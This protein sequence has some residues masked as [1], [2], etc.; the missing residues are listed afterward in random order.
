MEEGQVDVGPTLV[1]DVEAAEVGEPRHGALGDPAI[2]PQ[3]RAAF[4][5]LPGD[6]VR[7]PVLLQ[8]GVAARDIVGFVGVRLSGASAGA[9][10]WTL[11]R[12]DAVKSCCEVEGVVAIG[13]THQ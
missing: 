9:S 7:D 13:R 11:D 2:P 12:P 4:D 6:A 8:V 3:P 1:A 10:A 5:A